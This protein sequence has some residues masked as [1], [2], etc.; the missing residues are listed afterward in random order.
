MNVE[1]SDDAE[2]FNNKLTHKIEAVVEAIQ[3]L[4]EYE[5]RLGEKDDR[6]SMRDK[7]RQELSK[8]DKLIQETEILLKQFETMK[9]KKKDEVTKIIKRTKESFNK[10]KEKYA[11]VKRAI[12]SKEKIYLEPNRSFDG[13][14]THQA[15]VSL[16]VQSDI[17]I[18]VQ[19]ID[20]YD[21]MLEDRAKD[22]QE[23]RK[24]ADQLKGLAQDQADKLQENSE[25]IDVIE[26]HVEETE[27]YAEK[28]NKELDKKL[29]SQKILSKK[30]VMCCTI[31]AV[32]C[33]VAAVIIF[34]E[35][36]I[37]W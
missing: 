8:T 13:N 18:H 3:S 30:N 7:M 11:K 12:E 26:Q 10:Q 4:E 25:I 29:K 34:S 21:K 20:T 2:S 15:G 32:A 14:S 9:I 37:F 1:G 24:Y 22:V 6:K 16:Q 19:D 33:G 35:K 27:K 17:Q 36:L 5:A 28:G 31:L 23:I